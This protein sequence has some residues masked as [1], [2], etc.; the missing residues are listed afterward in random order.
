[1]K[2]LVLAL[3][4]FLFLDPH[5]VEWDG[6]PDKVDAYYFVQ[7]ANEADKIMRIE[8]IFDSADHDGTVYGWC[9]DGEAYYPFEADSEDYI[10]AGLKAC[11]EGT[12]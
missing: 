8:L 4:Y 2:A 9:F 11:E 3:A 12:E 1:M 6:I 10:S 7:T 5:P